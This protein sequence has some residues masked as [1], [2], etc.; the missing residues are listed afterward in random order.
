MSTIISHGNGMHRV[1]EV[2]DP[3]LQMI[4]LTVGGCMGLRP[5]TEG[6]FVWK[7]ELGVK[8][9]YRRQ[10]ER[11]SHSEDLFRNKTDGLGL[12]QLMHGGKTRLISKGSELAP[13]IADRINMVITKDGKVT[14]EMPQS[15]HLNAMLR[16]E[17]FLSC[18]RPADE[19][20]RNPHYLDDFTLVKPG[21]HDGGS[22][23]RILYVG[24]LPA[25]S[26]STVTIKAFLDVMDF[27]TNADRTNAVAAAITTLLRHRWLGEKP[28]VLITATK[29]HAG[30]GTIAEFVRGSVGKAGIL[31][32]S[33]DWPMLSQFQRQ[34]KLDPDLGVINIDNV[35]L[36]SAGGRGK[37]IR[38]AFVE[39]FVTN[40][41]VTLASPGAAEA[42]TLP[43]EYVVI[44]NTNDGSLSQDILNR[45]LPIHLA[46]KGGIHD[47]QSAIG[48]PKL[49]FLPKNRHRIDAELRGMIDRWRQAGCPLDENVK[50]SMSPW[51]K[52]I[53]GILKLN[54]FT[55]FLGNQQT[56]TASDDPLR[57]AIGI[58]GA[59]KP[60][61]AFRPADW[62]QV[63][64]QQGLAKTLIHA[65]ERDT[66]KGRE[67]AIGVVLSPLIGETFEVAT[68]TKHF[69]LKLDG[70]VRRWVPGKNPHVR[71]Q[72]IVMEETSLDLGP[73]DTSAAQNYFQDSQ[74]PNEQVRGS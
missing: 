17:V 2:D 20:A 40:A 18:F 38:S 60:G 9:N 32:E 4:P 22:G 59:S 37:F 43:N 74:P 8:T 26:D 15:T 71:Y 46:P 69:R 25:L 61:R 10:G 39:S 42:V 27:G 7:A 51:A 33:I 47:R 62:A 57:R 5:Q 41:E 6:K 23:R 64:V 45:A 44:I 21:Y 24:Q 3:A 55:D 29:S 13:V 53:G 52:T 28:L 30:K 35:R 67:R 34:V 66:Q 14:G 56:R 54:G 49:E 1:D 48:N 65:N 31:Y 68:D 19:I 11:L 50:H 63:V 72:F 12:I 36:D 58:L 73:G 16:S 70:G